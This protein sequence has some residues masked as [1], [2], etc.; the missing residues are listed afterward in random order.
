MKKLFAFSAVITFVFFCLFPIF[1]IVSTSLKSIDAFQARDLS[2]WGPGTGISNYIKLLTETPFLQ[3][4]FNSIL[5]SIAVTILGLALAS[6]SA[7][8]LS[9]FDFKSKSRLLLMILTTQM[10]PPTML[11]LP[12]YILLSKLKLIDSFW[13][14]LIIYASTALPF[15][16]WQMKSY[17]DSIPKEL[18]E[19]AILDGCSPWQVFSKIIFPL[20]KPGLVVTAL[21][22][23]T[24]AWCEY[25]VAAII[26]QD[27]DL[28]TLPLGLKSFQA[29][30]ATEWGLYSAS[31]ILVSLPVIFIFFFISRYLVSGLTS[32]SVKG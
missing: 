17:Y 24:S 16:I 14:L 15:C 12:F 9:R 22:S 19:A 32:G 20:S 8:V 7:Y 29:K 31:A 5:V 25:A 26:L 3:W 13:G 27:T 11:L 23:F 30:L 28:Y 1:Y 18:D 10:F 4:T 6:S 21:F 2:L